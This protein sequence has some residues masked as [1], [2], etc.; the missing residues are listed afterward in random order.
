VEILRKNH[1][2]R[3]SRAQNREVNTH[4][5]ERGR[6][7]LTSVRVEFDNK[8]STRGRRMAGG[9]RRRRR[10]RTRNAILPSIIRVESDNK[11][12]IMRRRRT[13]GVNSGRRQMENR[14]DEAPADD[15]PRE[16]DREEEERGKGCT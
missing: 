14:S 3:I 10:R 7:I 15:A 5:R 16:A 13:R 6:E 12:S 11:A 9:R 4:T 1:N 8:A 2:C